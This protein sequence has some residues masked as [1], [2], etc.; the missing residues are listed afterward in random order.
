MS[1]TL[2]DAPRKIVYVF[3]NY[4]SSLQGEGEIYEV[5]VVTGEHRQG[6]CGKSIF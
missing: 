1:K 3:L 4:K 2:L 5:V 6:R